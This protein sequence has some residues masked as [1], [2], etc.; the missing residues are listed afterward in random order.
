MYIKF[1]GSGSAFTMNNFQTN[2]LLEVDGHKLLIDC[3]TDIRFALAE[4]GLSYNDIDGVYISHQHSDHVGGLEYLGFCKYFDP[5]DCEPDL[6]ASADVL[7]SLWD[8]TLKGGMASLQNKLADIHT[9]FFTYE[10]DK[11][12]YFN[13]HGVT[14]RLVQSL[15]IMNEYF[16]VPAYGLMIDD[17]DM[18]VF[19]TSDTQH[20]PNQ[21][22]DFYNSADVIFHDC[23]TAPYYSG[24]HAHYDELKT[25]DDKTRSKMWLMHYQDNPTQDPV[26]DGFRGFV[27][28]GQVFEW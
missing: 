26:A 23:E 28:K 17:G 25:L 6:Y 12:G 8:N 11:N 9:Y 7:S 15:P 3:G 4:Q 14:C 13:W 1:L 16:F 18:K 21:I 22:Q 2:A 5:N 24:V 20:C 10:I 19:Y 27:Q